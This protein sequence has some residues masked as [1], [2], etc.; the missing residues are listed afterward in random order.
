MTVHNLLTTGPK[1]V[2]PPPPLGRGR[3]RAAHAFDA[4]LDDAELA[5]ARTA[6]AQGRWQTARSLL[7]RTGDEWDRRGHRVAVLAQ[8]QACVPW[9]RDWLLAEPDSV[10]AA[11]LLAL[12]QVRRALRGKE[13]PVRAREA[14]HAAAALAPVDPTPGSACSCW[15]APSVPSRRCA[16]SSPRSAPGTPTTTT[17]TI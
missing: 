12:G 17:P 15:R 16:A 11:V 5:A 3:K 8:E 10:D 7:A 14:C 4:A 13:K 9:T 6:L 2:S 1:P